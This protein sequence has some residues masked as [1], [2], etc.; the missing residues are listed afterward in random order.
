MLYS[1]DGWCAEAQPFTNSTNVNSGVLLNSPKTLY[2]HFHTTQKLHCH[3]HMCERRSSAR[4]SHW[5]HHCMYCAVLHLKRRIWRHELYECAAEER[6]EFWSTIFTSGI[7][8]REQNREST[9][10]KS[11]KNYV[12]SK[13]TFAYLLFVRILVCFLYCVNSKLLMSSS[14]FESRVSVSKIESRC[15][16]IPNKTRCCPT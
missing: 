5:G 3:M 8:S 13:I 7:F 12:H 9:T 1:S 2:A 15:A 4:M 10:Q 6:T 11:W 16:V 14:N